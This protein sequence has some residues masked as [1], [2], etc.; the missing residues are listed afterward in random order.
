MDAETCL[1]AKL[2]PPERRGV[3][4]VDPPYEEKNEAEKT[5]RMLEHG[6]RRFAQGVFVVWYPMKADQT[7]ETVLA[8][9]KDIGLPGTLKVEMRVREAF[10]GGGLAGSGLIILNAPWK[11]DEEL[12]LLVPAL[13][14]R[15]GIGSWGLSEVSW[16]NKP[17]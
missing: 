5:V 14:G 8:G 4:L 9:A 1:K 13:A 3:V 12:K 11:L 7:A 6:V 10:K 16:L 15:L 2:P 17:T